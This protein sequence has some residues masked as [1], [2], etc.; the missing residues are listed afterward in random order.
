MCRARP[1]AGFS[2]L[3]YELSA[4]AGINTKK[5]RGKKKQ[6]FYLSVFDKQ[7]E[8]MFVERSRNVSSLSCAADS[9]VF[10]QLRE[11]RYT[12]LCVRRPRRPL[13][14]FY[15]RTPGLTIRPVAA[16]RR[17]TETLQT[18]LCFQPIASRGG[19]SKNRTLIGVS[20]RARYSLIALTPTWERRGSDLS[21]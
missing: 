17:R 16:V 6:L 18:C 8:K 15:P 9:G 14:R 19:V 4:K 20:V 12:R 10:R 13:M 21:P 5:E 1:P 2:L 7:G 11:S 3:R